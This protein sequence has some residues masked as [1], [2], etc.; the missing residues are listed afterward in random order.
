MDVSTDP[1]T[2]DPNHILILNIF[3]EIFE[4][5]VPVVLIV[6]GLFGNLVSVGI[7]LK[8]DH[9]KVTTS[10]YMLALGILDMSVSVMIFF[11]FVRRWFKS[12][13][14][15]RTDAFC[16]AFIYCSWFFYAAAAYVI[17][18]MTFDRFVATYW[19]LNVNFIMSKRRTR[20][21]IIGSTVV[22]AGTCVPFARISYFDH[23]SQTCE[24]SPSL[25]QE[26]ADFLYMICST[27]MPFGIILVVNCL[28]TIKLT[29]AARERRH[30]AVTGKSGKDA[31]EIRVTLVLQA[32]SWI[33]L[34][35]G[36]PWYVVS[37]YWHYL[38]L[39]R[40]LT[41]LENL[42]EYLTKTVVTAVWMSS[43][44]INFYIYILGFKK[45][46]QD[47]M[48]IFHCNAKGK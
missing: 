31:G 39:E 47:V 22:A 24:E 12:A 42:V 48:A 33:F 13:S 11:Y 18:F 40:E 30:L 41:V 37:N 26:I 28:I 43:H 45:F 7:M 46:Q 19:P 5:H 20:L 21:F 44:C 15:L 8:P 16:K 29:S 36:L 14:F 35:G 23:Q 1:P 38:R 34:L 27:I 10:M 6:L 32:I 25:L 9:R 17:V 2:L 4:Y 3:I